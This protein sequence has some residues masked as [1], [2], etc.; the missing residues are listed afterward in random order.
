MGVS[1]TNTSSRIQSLLIDLYGIES[2][3]LFMRR[4]E[5]RIE[6]FNKDKGQISVLPTEELTERDSILISYGDMLREANQPPL[7]TLQA[8]CQSYLAGVISSIHILPF[9]P[10]S[11]DDG[12]SVM[13]Y[14][15]VN[16]QLG[17]WDDIH[18]LGYDFRLMF[19]A[20]INHVSAE[21]AWFE[22]FIQNNPRYQEYFT[23]VEDDFDFSN[24]VRPR[25]SPALTSFQTTSGVKDVWTTFS[26]DQ[27]DLN[28]K[29][30]EVL[31][32]IIDLMLF[33]V[34]QGAQLIRLDAI[35][36]IWKESGTTCLHLPQVHKIVQIIRAV[37]DL[38]APYVK[39]ITE[40]NVPHQDNIAYFGDGTNEAQL[41][42]NFPLPPLLLHTFRTG[43]SQILSDWATGLQLP[44]DQ[45]TFFNFLASHDGIGLNPIRGIIEESEINALV[46]Q[47][48]EHGGLIN[49]RTNPDGSSS[50]YELNINYFDALNNPFSSEPLS[51][52]IDRFMCAQAIMLALVG[53]PGIYFHSLVGSRSWREGVAL[54][55]QNRTIN[56]Q[57]L[58]RLALE[59]ELQ[60]VDTVREQVFQR[61]LSL[62]RLRGCY[63]HFNPYGE[64]T[65][66]DCGPGVFGLR[67]GSYQGNKPFLVCLH[68]ITADDQT[69]DEE[70]MLTWLNAPSKAEPIDLISGEMIQP[71]QSGSI[72]LNPYQVLWIAV[73]TTSPDISR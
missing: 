29:N 16:P 73:R 6:A 12:F 3:T 59:R 68:N 67:R 58:D 27:V 37:F 1:Q 36:F 4:L 45:T 66:L 19:D 63:P 44:S 61:Y 48:K 42:Y 39:I 10:W 5:D 35:A 33:Y 25:T 56:R 11:S 22:G 31:F 64:Q 24:L 57:K 17:N 60:Q 51:R 43:S 30:P 50:P 46:E 20:V 54:S 8:F 26:S 70:K 7:Q 40:T 53:V 69:V 41:V 34:G 23:I 65:I 14:W 38:A 52:Q 21:S 9:Y 32:E 47:V 72:R 62:L 28:F 55:R 49:S 15:A 18:Q 71:G 2:A 13:D